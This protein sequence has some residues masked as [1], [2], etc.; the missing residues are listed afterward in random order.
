MTPENNLVP[1]SREDIAAGLVALGATKGDILYARCGLQAVGVRSKDIEDVFLGGI[2]DAIGPDGTLI[3]PAFVK[4]SRRWSKPLAVSSVEAVP[5]TGAFSKLVLRQPGAYRSSHPTHSF[6]GIGA[7]AEAILRYHPDNGACFEPIRPMVEQDGLMAVIGCVKSS[8]GFSTVHLAQHDLGLSQRHYTKL[9]VAVRQGTA[10]GPV[11]HPIE[12]PGCSDNFGV[13]Y[14][15]Y[16][17][18]E[19][20]KCGY[21]GRA[22]SIAVRAQAAYARERDILAR[23]PLYPVC[24]RRDC[25]SCHTLRGYNKRA[26]PGALIHRAVSRLRGRSAA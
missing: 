23:D 2:W 17:E 4:T 7:K 19:N 15:D 20:F 3:T 16:V 14:K 21:V 9:F 5:Y 22:W 24:E 26:V 18:D 8:P 10:T 13:F 12:A 6:V 11:F 1:V 25:L